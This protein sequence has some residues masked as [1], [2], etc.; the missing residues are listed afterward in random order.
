MD[1]RK[2]PIARTAKLRNPRTLISLTPPLQG[3]NSSIFC[4]VRHRKI[5]A[6]N[7]HKQD[8]AL[9]GLHF[10][11]QMHER[12]VLIPQLLTAGWDGFAANS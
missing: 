9:S 10:V 5:A 7:P 4:G 1:N 3:T 6:P 11:F 12:L 2:K 8:P